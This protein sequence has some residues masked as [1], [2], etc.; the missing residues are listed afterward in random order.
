MQ[1]LPELEEAPTARLT[2]ISIFVETWSKIVISR[3]VLADF[4]LQLHK[5][6]ITPSQGTAQCG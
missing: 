5:S 4:E 3:R 1:T 6:V 2:F